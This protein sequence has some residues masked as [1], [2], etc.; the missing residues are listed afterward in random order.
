MGPRVVIGPGGL[1]RGYGRRVVILPFPLAVSQVTVRGRQAGHGQAGR[2]QPGA[3]E[4]GSAG[5]MFKPAVHGSTAVAVSSLPA[6]S[7]TLW[8]TR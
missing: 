1:T 8:A 7:A 5:A 4:P 2:V 3:G 6:S